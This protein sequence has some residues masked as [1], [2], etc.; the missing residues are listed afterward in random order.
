M[1]ADDEVNQLRRGHAA[2]RMG[3]GDTLSDWEV[4]PHR[5]RCLVRRTVA[6]TKWKRIHQRLTTFLD[7]VVARQGQPE[8][9]TVSNLRPE[10]RIYG[11]RE[12][13][14]VGLESRSAQEPS[15]PLSHHR[16][17]L[18]LRRYSRAEPPSRLEHDV[19]PAQGGRRYLGLVRQS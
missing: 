1:K 7:L 6:D 9:I 4:T 3:D 2:L 11:R 13:T 16:L 10:C 5:G 18:L 8:L 17:F 19:E 15:G 12:M 14:G